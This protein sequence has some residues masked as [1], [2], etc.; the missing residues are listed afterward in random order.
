[1]MGVKFNYNNS[2]STIS[3]AV[4]Y[5]S[6]NTSKESDMEAEINNI[7]REI[8]SLRKEMNLKLSNKIEIIFE[9]NSFWDEMKPELIKLLGNRLG[10]EIIFMDKLEEYKIIKTFMDTELKVNVKLLL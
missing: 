7:R 5:L 8:N 10:V 4:L 3:Q 6:T 9:K 2:N 1:M